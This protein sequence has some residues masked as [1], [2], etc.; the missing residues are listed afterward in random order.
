M[1]FAMVSNLR[2]LNRVLP[3]EEK[4]V[5]CEGERSSVVSSGRY[6]VYC[7]T[8]SR[9]ER[10]P[11]TW[12]E[13]PYIM[14]KVLMNHGSHR[15]DL[16]VYFTHHKKIMVLWGEGQATRFNLRFK[17]HSWQDD[18]LY[19]YSTR[20]STYTGIIMDGWLWRYHHHSTLPLWHNWCLDNKDTCLV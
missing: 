15:C 16:E 20:G 1:I 13:L 2:I 11:T 12:N 17:F 4:L 8:Q 3:V 7:D 5:S 9:C 18:D 19:Y 6:L 10:S 14:R